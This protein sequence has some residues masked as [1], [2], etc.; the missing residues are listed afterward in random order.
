MQVVVHKQYN[1]IQCS[2]SSLL[3]TFVDLERVRNVRRVVHA[4][5]DDE[6]EVGGGHD[7]DLDV[8]PILITIH[9]IIIC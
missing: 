5:S 1:I 8:P 7:V 9:I 3:L 2:S 6:D 4:E